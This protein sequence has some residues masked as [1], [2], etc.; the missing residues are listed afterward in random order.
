MFSTALGSTAIPALATALSASVMVLA[1]V[2]LVAAIGATVVWVGRDARARGFRS[3]WML[4][5]IHI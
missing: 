2:I 1:L 3:V 4:S 5:L